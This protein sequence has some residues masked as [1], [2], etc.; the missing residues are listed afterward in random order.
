MDTKRAVSIN[1]VYGKVIS[2]LMS[3]RVYSLQIILNLFNL[4]EVG[5]FVPTID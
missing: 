3:F 5:H 4:P 1:D 2:Y